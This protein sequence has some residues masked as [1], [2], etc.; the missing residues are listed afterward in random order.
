MITSSREV[1][2]IVFVGLDGGPAESP[3][4]NTKLASWYHTFLKHMLDELFEFCNAS[5]LFVYNKV[6]GRMTSLSKDTAGII[7][8]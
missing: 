7:F 6:E 8:T 3:V 5:G 4:H 2:P 1:E